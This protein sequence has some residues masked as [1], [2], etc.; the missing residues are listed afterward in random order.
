MHLDAD[1]IVKR[2]PLNDI[3]TAT[4]IN[5]MCLVSHPG[6][7]RPRGLV[8]K[9]RFYLNNPRMF[10]ID[11]R[12]LTKMGGLG[13]WETNQQSTAFVSRERRRNYVCGGTWFGKRVN[14]LELVSKLSENVAQDLQSNKI[15]IWHDESHLNSWAASNFH[16]SLDPKFCFVD[17]YP[18]LRGLDA[19]I[20]AVDKPVSTR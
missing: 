6:Y 14:F 8:D 4:E 19:V 18:Q 15:A 5:S 7:W 9:T 20:M 17:G 2:S 16:L 10:L 11:L 12:M 1:M 13:S 3:F